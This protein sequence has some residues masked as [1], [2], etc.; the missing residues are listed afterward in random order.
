MVNSVNCNIP[1]PDVQ[2]A[3]RLG[4]NISEV[5]RNA[6]RQR[7]AKE[8]KSDKETGEGRQ[9]HTPA[10]TSKGDDLSVST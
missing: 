9:T 4:I 3:R 5:A 7:L 8:K 10:I 6:L 2:E 1:W